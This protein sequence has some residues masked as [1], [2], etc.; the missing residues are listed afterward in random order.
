MAIHKYKPID[1]E[2]LY[3]D[4]DKY[5]YSFKE[6]HECSYLYFIIAEVAKNNFAYNRL[7]IGAS[8]HPEFRLNELQTGNPYDLKIWYTI[9]VPKKI[10]YELERE[11]HQKFNK[12][13]IRGEWFRLD[14]NIREWVAFHKVKHDEI[15]QKIERPN[16]ILRKNPLSIENDDNLGS[17]LGWILNYQ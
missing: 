4:I 6:L 13:N 9:K 8:D 16:H 2:T 3:G 10:V 14:K 5:L 12:F 17:E 15:I 11:L 1:N 7:K